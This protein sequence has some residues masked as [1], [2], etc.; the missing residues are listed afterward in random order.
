VRVHH[1][2]SVRERAIT[3]LTMRIGFSFATPFVRDKPSDDAVSDVLTGIAAS[4]G[5]GSGAGG[6]GALA[7][8]LGGQNNESYCAASATDA[9]DNIVRRCDKTSDKVSVHNTHNTT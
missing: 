8:A 5:S 2:Q 1:N 3:T 6:G 9:A 7:R 4:S